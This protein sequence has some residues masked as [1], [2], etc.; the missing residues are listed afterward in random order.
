MDAPVVSIDTDM[1]ATR[2]AELRAYA[3]SLEQY[4]QTDRV[5]PAQLLHQVGPVY[6]SYVNAKAGEADA[7][8]AAYQ[9]V[10]K[11]YRDAADKLDNTRTGITN[12]DAASGQAIDAIATR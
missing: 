6:E 7:R 9:R 3:D 10:A 12:E 2:A 11:Q 4:G 5:S 8:K 1:A